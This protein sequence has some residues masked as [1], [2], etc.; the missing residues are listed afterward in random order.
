MLFLRLEVLCFIA[1]FLYIIYYFFDR[2]FSWYRVQKLQKLEKQRLKNE[3]ESRKKSKTSEVAKDEETSSQINQTRITQE[4]S[5]KLREISKRAQVNI[6]RGY[7]ESARILIVEGL[8]LKKDDKELNLLL[9][10]VY[11][12]EKNYKNAAYIY[13]DMLETYEDDEFILQR[14]WNIY[15][16]LWKNKKSFEIYQRAHKKNRVNT[17][18][19]DILSYLSLELQDFKKSLKYTNLFLKEKPRNSEKLAI[20]GFCLEKVW[21]KGEAV[22]AY[23]K[24]LEI[25]PYNTEVQ[26]RLKKLES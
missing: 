15:A 14:L 5:E 20:K 8:T 7:Y 4:Q 6:S 17:E 1:S 23:R 26:D 10:D 24:V 22:T 18:I 19:L 21:K 16:L 25:Q 12:R 11:E 9:A 13:N 2:T 3:R